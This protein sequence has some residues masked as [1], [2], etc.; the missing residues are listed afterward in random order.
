MHTELV[1]TAQSNL[2]ISLDTLQVVREA[3]VTLSCM[4]VH[5]G[6]ELTQFVEQLLPQLIA[7]LSN[8]AKV[9]SSSANLCVIFIIK[10]C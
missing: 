1:M 2:Q 9:M 6:T 3:S 7:L 10:V 4:C 5:L 8:S